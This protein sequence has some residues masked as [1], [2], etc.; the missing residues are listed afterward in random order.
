MIPESSNNISTQEGGSPVKI[1][2]KD[3]RETFQERKRS[4]RDSTS[5]DPKFKVN[6]SINF[7]RKNSNG[8]GKEVHKASS[9]NKHFVVGDL[10][11]SI[12]SIMIKDKADGA[13]K[14]E[15]SS[16]FKNIEKLKGK[17][18][19]MKESNCARAI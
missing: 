8:C 11:R 10:N 9:S 5:L 17:S 4:L 12:E 14:G 2:S 1:D 15:T 13:S 7:D 3:H 18:Q 16:H 6:K 19:H